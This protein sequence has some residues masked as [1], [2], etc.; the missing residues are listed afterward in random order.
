[1]VDAPSGPTSGVDPQRLVSDY[2]GIDRRQS[3]PVSWL[4]HPVAIRR[5]CERVSGDPSV[6]TSQYWHQHYFSTPA[7]LGLS[8]GCGFGAFERSLI[9]AGVVEHF[10]AHD[11]SEEAIAGAKRNAEAAG[12]RDRIDYHVT[13]LNSFSVPAATYDAIFAISSVH[14]VFA[15][16]NLFKQCRQ[17]L[18]P[19]ALLFLD[20]YIGPSRFQCPPFVSRVINRLLQILPESYRR[21]A[22]T[23]GALTAGYQNSPI[24]HFDAID[25][26]EAVRS[27]EIV[28]ILK[29]Y[30][31]IVD[32]KPYGGA[33]LHMLL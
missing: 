13:D 26:S 7:S 29:L 30:F 24:A 2:W 19:G 23:G 16:E 12:L 21:N 9:A 10:H 5:L 33:I 6:G 25:P 31:D 3:R 11:L 14:H 17:A 1:M 20:E 8:I 28:P 18:K 27:G 15:L 22:L 32:Y 4:E